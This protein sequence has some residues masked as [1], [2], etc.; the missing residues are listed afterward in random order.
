MG[1]FEIRK[2]GGK[3]RGVGAA[4]KGFGKANY[5]YKNI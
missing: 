4:K 1:G 3:V 5:S 2:S